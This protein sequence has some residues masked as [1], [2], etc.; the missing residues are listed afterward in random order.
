MHLIA[1]TPESTYA[2]EG[3]SVLEAEGWTK[4]PENN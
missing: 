1:F 4:D 3:L 2:D